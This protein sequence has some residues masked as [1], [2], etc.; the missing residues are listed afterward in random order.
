M[1]VIKHP[2][3]KGRVRVLE[4]V[5][6]KTVQLAVVGHVVDERQLYHLHVAEIIKVAVGIPYIC[7]A[8]AHTGSEVTACGAEHHGASA[9][10]VFAAV[11]AHAFDNSSGTRIAHTEAFADTTV[12]VYLT[13]CSS[14]KESVAGYDIFFG[15]E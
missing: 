1:P 9:C 3:C 10:H 8:S 14:I 15:C 7:H 12:D 11:V 2:S 4:V 6:D 13:G 5:A